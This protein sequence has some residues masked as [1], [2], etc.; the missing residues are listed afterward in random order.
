MRVLDLRVSSIAPGLGDGPFLS[1]DGWSTRAHPTLSQTRYRVDEFRIDGQAEMYVPDTASTDGRGRYTTRVLA[2]RPDADADFSGVVHIELLNPSTGED[3][4]MFWPDA[5]AHVMSR[6]DAYLGI[7]C[8]TVTALDLRERDP[9]RY[10]DLVIGDDSA[11]W[12]ILG[13][14]ARACHEPEAAGLL[15]G[16]RAPMR[17]FATGWS[18]SGS[19][20][21]TYLSERL[22]DRHSADLPTAAHILDGYLIGVSSGGFGPMGYIEL[23]RDGEMAFDANFRPLAGGEPAVPMDDA[24]RILLHAPVPVI[25]YM[26]QDEAVHHVWHRRPDSDLPGDSYRCYQVPGRGHETGL[27]RTS[28]RSELAGGLDEDEIDPPRHESSRFVLAAVVSHLVAW[29]DGITPPRADP[30][31]VAVR[32]PHRIDPAGVDFAH[33]EIVPDELGHALGGIRHLEVDCPTARWGIVPSGPL[34][35]RLWR[36]VALTPAELVAR[37]RDRDAYVRSV[38]ARAA[39]LVSQGWLLPEH[40]EPAVRDAEERFLRTR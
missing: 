2:I 28:E 37:Y 30:I 3:F 26:S 10:D 16:L 17:R 9:A 27:L 20:L 39:E 34:T 35:M 11:V 31:G 38:R 21:R 40:V 18:Q 8:K 5:G 14:V 13:A 24:R 32:A 25:E 6:G 36:C 4:P 1:P 15:P 29:T 12:S 19:F 7:T 23:D 33:V 22:H